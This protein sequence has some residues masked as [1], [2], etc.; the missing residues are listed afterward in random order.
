VCVTMKV[1]LEQLFHVVKVVVASALMAPGTGRRRC[2]LS[3]R[4]ASGRE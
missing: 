3:R 2:R 1:C 4:D